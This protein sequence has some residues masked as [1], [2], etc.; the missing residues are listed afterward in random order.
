MSLYADIANLFKRK[1]ELDPLDT[2]QSLDAPLGEEDNEFSLKDTLVA[3]KKEN[4]EIDNISIRMGPFFKNNP[5]AKHLFVNTV[6]EAATNIR[7]NTIRYVDVSGII[8]TIIATVR[9]SFADF[10][11]DSSGLTEK[12]FKE[13]LSRVLKDYISNVNSVKT[14]SK[15][16]GTTPSEDID[17]ETQDKNRIYSGEIIS[18]ITK[19]IDSGEVTVKMLEDTHSDINVKDIKEAQRLLN[20]SNAYKFNVRERLITY[21]KDKTPIILHEEVESSMNLAQRLF[22]SITDTSDTAFNLINFCIVVRNEHQSGYENTD[23]LSNLAQTYF[24][25]APFHG[26]AAKLYNYCIR[27]S[28]ILPVTF[29]TNITS[30]DAWAMYY[31]NL[32]KDK[33]LKIKNALLD[34]AELLEQGVKALKRNYIEHTTMSS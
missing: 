6:A 26:D 34:T 9:D 12:N 1:A 30:P 14:K 25:Y 24:N 2:A 23:V 20:E 3:P 21:T 28:N 4:E 8:D 16:K 33:Q 27:V 10:L 13:H 5:Q 19:R 17:V 15:I 29:S 32:N 7:K 22:V 31:S 18:S 11:K